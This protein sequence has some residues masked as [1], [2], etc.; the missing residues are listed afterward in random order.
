MA[1]IL[2]NKIK[3]WQELI[4][5]TDCDEAVSSDSELVEN[6]VAAGENNNVT[7]S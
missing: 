7:G 2:R 3:I 5:E 4:S 6:T 1:Q